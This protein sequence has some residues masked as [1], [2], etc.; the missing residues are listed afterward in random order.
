MRKEIKSKKRG[1]T[2]KAVAMLL[3]LTLGLCS[4]GINDHLAETL[5][6]ERL[7][8]SDPVVDSPVSG[9]ESLEEG[10]QEASFGKTDAGEDNKNANAGTTDISITDSAKEDTAGEGPWSV[11][12]T[13]NTADYTAED[14]TL[15]FSFR[16][17][18]LTIY[19]SKD[20]D[21]AAK[22]QQVMD[23]LHLEPEESLEF[24]KEMYDSSKKDNYE[25]YPNSSELTYSMVQ[26]DGYLSIIMDNYEYTG[27]AHGMPYENCRVFGPD[28]SRLMLSD[29]FTDVEAARAKVSEEVERQIKEQKKE[30]PDN[31]FFL[32]MV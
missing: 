14:G 21:A 11:A 17:D 29:L 13:P 19:N 7:R 9:E 12:I 22:V 3:A 15:I 25:F 20:P 4:C 24:A 10:S 30:D 5:P 8:Q 2:A 26:T 18:I 27:G 16:S 1:K 23:E 31:M 6:M 32:R 28:G